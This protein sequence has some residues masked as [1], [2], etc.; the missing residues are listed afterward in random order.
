MRTGI[1]GGTFDPIHSGHLQLAQA[2]LGQLGLDRVL[3]MPSGEPPYKKP[4]A[5]RADRLI[6]ARRAADDLRG[7][8]VCEL[9]ILRPGPTYAVDTLRAL[10]R[11]Y[12]EDELVYILGSDAAARVCRWKNADEAHRLCRFAC[13]VRSGAQDAVPEGML[14]LETA[15]PDISSEAIRAEIAAGGTA[16]DVL[17]SNVARYISARGL[18]LAAM[19]EAEII[20]ELRRSLKPGRFLHTLGVVDTSVELARIYGAPEG[21]ALYAS[22]LH[23]CAKNLAEGELVKMAEMVGA[24]KDEMACAPVL[25][26]PAGAYLARERYGVHDAEV[27]CAIRRHTVGAE[28]MSLLDAIIYVADMIEPGRRFFAGLDDARALARRDIFRAAALCGRLTREYAR[29]K[30]S[31]HPTTEKMI[32]RIENGGIANG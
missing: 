27:L 5:G 28:D 7:V 12:P 16:A 10:R 13:V 15:I 30:G 6:M 31:L 8:E 14:K 3:L 17:P 20:A 23:D 18:Y 2:A 24:D 4:L 11:I 32:E 25:H 19:P 29:G 26:A 1:F 9:E 22:L 21:K